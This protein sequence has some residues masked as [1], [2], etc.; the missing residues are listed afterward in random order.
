MSVR[1]VPTQAMPCQIYLTVE[2][3]STALDQLAAVLATV[4]VAS[5]LISP[6]PGQTLTVVTAKPLVDFVQK[7]NVAAL[8][9]DDPVLART[10]R[11]DG[12]HL[13][14]GDD[15]L[16]RYQAAR[17]RLGAAASIGADAG[18]SRHYAMQ[19]GEAGADYIAFSDARVEAVVSEDQVEGPSTP[20]QLVAW[21]SEV[22]EVPCVAL[23][24]S[25]PEAAGDAANLGA[26]FVAVPLLA[27]QTIAAAVEHIRAVHT[28]LGRVYA[29]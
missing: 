9:A 6:L 3:S 20:A 22:F 21:W 12:V 19:L 10:V 29:T 5:V 18:G 15:C 8:L 14:A 17:L 13:R 26:D 7:N 1:V 28:A 23:D 24:L 11:A 16:E 4:P 25:N 27:G 2:A